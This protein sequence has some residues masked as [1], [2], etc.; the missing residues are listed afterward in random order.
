MSK[1]YGSMQGNRGEATRRGT[2]NSG[3]KA[4]V[5]GWNCGIAVNAL[6][7]HEEEEIFG[8]VLTK[9]STDPSSI[10]SLLTVIYN[11]KTRKTR[12]LLPNKTELVEVGEC[13]IVD[14]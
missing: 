10:L 8:V 13:E 12:V 9:G 7:T 3:M 11:A 5:R 2:A 1:F 4:H 14:K 6:A